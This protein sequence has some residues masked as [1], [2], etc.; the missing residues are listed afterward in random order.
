MLTPREKYVLLR[1]G[2]VKKLRT[3]L[4]SPSDELL[5]ELFLAL[6]DYPV[7]I[8]TQEDRELL[9]D[10]IRYWL[11]GYAVP[12]TALRELELRHPGLRGLEE[13]AALVLSGE[14]IAVEPDVNLEFAREFSRHVDA[15]EVLDVASGFGWIPVLLSKRAKVF[16]L[17]K[18]Y[19]NRI[20]YQR[21]RIVIEGTTIE[22]FPGSPAAR[23]Y[24]RR[25]KDKFRDYRDFA[26][27]FWSS[28]GAEMGNITLLQGDA[29]NMGK[30]RDLTNGRDYGIASGSIEAVT[31]FFGFNHI[32]SWREALKEVYRVLAKGGEAWITLYREYLEKFPLKFAYNWA[33]QLGVNMV[34]IKEFR[35]LAAKLGF[36]INPIN[37]YQGSTL[38]YLFQLKK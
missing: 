7:E 28:R 4:A 35:E 21:D 23:E 37:K 18:A 27:L 8:I 14:E 29:S 3:A 2:A 33:E 19:L 26:C 32:P 6:A 24:M 30:C 36:K 34:K 31:C 15:R 9:L 12:S 38:Y 20:L 11:R 25:R 16:A 22:L 17:D 13:K 5:E 1:P 10:N